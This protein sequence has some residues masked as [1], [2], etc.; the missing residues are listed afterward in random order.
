MIDNNSGKN[1]LLVPNN[2]ESPPF[3]LK[4]IIN[5]HINP[6][7]FQLINFPSHKFQM[8]YEDKII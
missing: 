4:Y 6:R 2:I 5:D 7:I 3:Y 8:I 1:S